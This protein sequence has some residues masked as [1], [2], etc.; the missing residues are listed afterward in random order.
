MPWR[1]AETGEFYFE[2]SSTR[3]SVCTFVRQLRG[4]AFEYVGMV[5]EPIE[6]R[7]DRSGVA[8]QL[9]PVI[10]GSIR[11]EQR[12]GA[13]VASDDQLQEITFSAITGSTSAHAFQ[14]AMAHGLPTPLSRVG[15]CCYRAG[16]RA[17]ASRSSWRKWPIS[18]ST[19]S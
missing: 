1:V 5:Q 10:D 4:P 17:S 19:A 15:A 13:L 14:L 7:G 18:I 9:A 2:P 12:G 16:R 8:E 11:R 6:Q 3:K